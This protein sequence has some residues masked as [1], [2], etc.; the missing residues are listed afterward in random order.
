MFVVNKLMI[1]RVSL[2]LQHKITV[3]R[4][5]LVCVT[6]FSM[7]YIIMLDVLHMLVCVTRVS[8]CYTF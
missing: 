8:M 6:H 3:T 7:C 2:H 5:M 4:Y 1:T